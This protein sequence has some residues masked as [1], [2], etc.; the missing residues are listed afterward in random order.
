MQYFRPSLSYQLSF[1]PFL[2]IF[3]WLF[4]TGFSVV[5]FYYELILYVCVFSVTSSEKVDKENRYGEFC[6]ASLPYPGKYLN[7]NLIIFH[8]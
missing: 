8:R 6:I 2:S 5:C 7:E 3:E 4:Y 1:R